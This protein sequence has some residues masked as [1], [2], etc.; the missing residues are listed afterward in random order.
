MLALVACVGCTDD[1]DWA[2]PT[3]GSE[4]RALT[5]P[6]P[7]DDLLFVARGEL[8]VVHAETATTGTV[9]LDGANPVTWF[10]DRPDRDAGLMGVETMLEEFGWGH[11][12]DTL[13][14]DPPNATLTADG[15]DTVV[16]EL[17]AATVDDD[18]VTFDVTTLGDGTLSSGPLR[19]AEL[20]IDS[21]SI[22]AMPR[23]YS[24]DI[25]NGVSLVVVITP[26]SYGNRDTVRAHLESDAGTQDGSLFLSDGFPYPPMAVPVGP[27]VV[28]LDGISYSPPST[29]NRR[30]NVSAR[31]TVTDASGANPVPF[32]ITVRTP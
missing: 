20:F 22:P 4:P 25:G 14:E 6:P 13:G 16:V 29:F 27:H 15:H 12:G 7:G 3:L 1:A 26:A 21:V 23:T 17:T 11:D 31:G 28:Q 19:N 24:G 2:A 10:S 30:P 5:T 32:N 9:T 8:G 18:T